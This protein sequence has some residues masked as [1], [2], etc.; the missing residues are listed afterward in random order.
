MPT[1][2]Y[3]MRDRR[4]G[5]RVPLQVFLTQYVRDRPIRALARDI[6]DTGV[7][8]QTPEISSQ[9]PHERRQIGLEIEL[10]GTGE[11]IWARGEVCHSEGDDMVRTS[12]IRFTAIPTHYARILRDYCIDS[13][14]NHLGSLL[15]RIRNPA[16]PLP[17]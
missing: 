2:S 1:I 12:G 8:L 6:S 5:F 15:S 9:V 13:R 16:L 10:P 11:V 4:L 14:R 7:S 3:M 17:G